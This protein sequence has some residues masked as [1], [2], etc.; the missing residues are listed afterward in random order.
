MNLEGRSLD[1]RGVAL[2][3]FMVKT[4]ETVLI[5]VGKNE[6]SFTTGNVNVSQPCVYLHYPRAEERRFLRALTQLVVLRL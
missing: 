2:C 1:E 4:R 5:K 3:C 6:N